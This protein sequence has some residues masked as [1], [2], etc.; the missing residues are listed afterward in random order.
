MKRRTG[1]TLI[2]L[3]VVLAAIGLLMAGALH[4]TRSLDDAQRVRD[5]R[6]QLGEIRE[7][8]LGF[9]VRVGRLPCPASPAEAGAAVGTEDRAAGGACNRLQ[10][11]LPWATLG[12]GRADAFGRP[13]S[14]RVTG[15]YADT[16]PDTTAS[17]PGDKCNGAPPPAGVSF[18]M[19]SLGDIVVRPE[20]G[21][22]AELARDIAAVVVSHGR[23][24]PGPL[25]PGGNGDEAGNT[26]DD[27]E[28]VSRDRVDGPGG[29]VVYDDLT[30][31]LAPTTVLSRML[32]AGRLP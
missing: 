11:L 3:A 30:D 9:V 5:T 24:G 10:G 32:A 8:L 27:A 19:C 7:A 23:N 1:F 31:W 15:W 4:A 16:S 28:F 20:A 12:L 25:E 21:S 2:E 22:A 6:A 13:F 18:A 26:G 14:Y 17:S 29:A